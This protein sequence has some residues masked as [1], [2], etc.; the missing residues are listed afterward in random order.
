[1]KQ[2]T[3]EDENVSGTQILAHLLADKVDTVLQSEGK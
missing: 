1:M 3:E 2:K